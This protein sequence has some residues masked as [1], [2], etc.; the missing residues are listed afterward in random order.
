[1]DLNNLITMIALSFGGGMFGAAIGGLPSF[2]L[3]GFGAVIGLAIYLVTGDP[4]F[5]DAVAWGPFLGPHIAFAGGVAA[6]AYAGKTGKL[7]GGGKDIVTPLLGLNAPDVL[8]VGG[9]FG[10]LGYVLFWVNGFLPMIGGFPW[11][12]PAVFSICITAVI[13]RLM[14]GKK[15]MFGKVRAGDSRWV[16][17]DVAAWLPWQSRPAQ[18]LL[19][20]IAIGLPIAYLIKIMPALF[21]FGFAIAAVWLVFL[22]VGFKVPVGHHIGIASGMAVIATGDIWWGMTFA[23]IGA[24]LGEFFACLFLNHGDT[25]IDPP[26]CSVA[27]TWL[28]T[29]ILSVTSLRNITGVAS[30]GVAVVVSALLYFAMSALKSRG[31]VETRPAPA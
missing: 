28:L 7:E 4:T 10:A 3:C 19:T 12:N 29:A 16:P 13:V 21:T 1:M 17:S 2:V 26:V 6:A 27:V 11:M 18:L 31:A 30:V 25:H 14:F 22:G 20:G 8:L 15:G 24:F 23:V 9:A 5:V